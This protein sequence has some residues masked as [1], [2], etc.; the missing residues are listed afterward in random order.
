M[1]RP[2]TRLRINPYRGNAIEYTTPILLDTIGTI[3]LIVRKALSIHRIWKGQQ[4][5][6]NKEMDGFV[7]L[8]DYIPASYK[9]GS[10][11]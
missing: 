9:I 3:E 1:P 11:T 10:S 6:S 4:A 5:G 8:T 7:L 2:R